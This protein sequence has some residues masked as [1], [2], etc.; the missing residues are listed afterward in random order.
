VTGGSIV[1]LLRQGGIVVYPLVV[2]SIV[3]LAIVLE[4]AWAV[5]GEAR[6]SRGLRTLVQEALGESG[7]AEAMALCRRDRSLLGAVYRAVLGNVDKPPEVR[8]R[9]AERHLAEAGRRLRRF[10]WLL[11]T[12]GSLAPFIGL[13]GTVVGIIRSF[14]S[15]AATGSG[16]FAV[17]AAGISEA[18][19]ATAGGLFVGVLSIFAYNAFMVRIQSLTAEQREAAEDLLAGLEQPPAAREGALRRV[20]PPR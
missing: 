1:G 12:I 15:M 11:G 7:I 10:V 18:L 16:G 4:R 9:V 3:T 6:A 20:P 5:L 17:V 8:T 19:I 13:F 14:E 2:C